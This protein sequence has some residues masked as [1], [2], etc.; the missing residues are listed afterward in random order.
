MEE[1]I[2]KLK[3]YF[4]QAMEKGLVDTA[5]NYC[6]HAFKPIEQGKFLNIKLSPEGT[7]IPVSEMAREGYELMTV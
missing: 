5:C 3:Q 6:V 2:E 1:P 7:H 4:D